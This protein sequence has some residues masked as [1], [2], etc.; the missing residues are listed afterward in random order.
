MSL[1]GLLQGYW[2]FIVAKQEVSIWKAVGSG[3]RTVN[4][5][6]KKGASV[7][8]AVL[9]LHQRPIIE[10]IS[11]NIWHASLTIA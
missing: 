11:L 8:E 2:S 5:S 4:A 3:V 7:L 10:K 9:D 1:G 6:G